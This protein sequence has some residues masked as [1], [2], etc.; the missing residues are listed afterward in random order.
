MSTLYIATQG[1]VLRSS[2]GRFVVTKGDETLQE[3]PEVAL[4]AAMLLGYIQVTTQAAHNLTR[5]DST[6]LRPPPPWRTRYSHL[7]LDH[8][9]LIM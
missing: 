4:D 8:R 3:I 5:K 7:S 1:A 9:D 6:A 2:A